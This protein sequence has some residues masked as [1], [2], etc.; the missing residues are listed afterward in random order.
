[1]LR[2]F[3]NTIKCHKIRLNQ[4]G[5]Y[6]ILE[7][8][9]WSST[10]MSVFDR[11]AKKLQRDRSVQRY[12]QISR[13]KT[14]I[15]NHLFLFSSNV[16]TYDYIR[17]SIAERLV[18]RIF[19]MTKEIKQV[20]EIGCNCGYITRHELPDTIKKFQLCDS[21]ELMLKQAEAS[22]YKGAIEYSFTQ[23]DEEKPTVSGRS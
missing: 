6:A 5:N 9:R 4:F 2:K 12:F 1:M 20:A 15:F 22:V 3:V 21:S 14:K 16:D 8:K 19:D 18:D 17:S 13:S 23:M 10:H 11:N 7:N